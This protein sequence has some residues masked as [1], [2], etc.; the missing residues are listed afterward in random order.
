[1]LIRNVKYQYRAF[2]RAIKLLDK[3]T[4]I[5]LY[6]S[7]L[8]SR[9]NYGDCVWDRCTRTDACRLQSVQNMAM[10][11]MA[12]AKPLE[13]AR[14][15]L[16]EW[17]LLSLD[18]KRLLRSLVLFYKLMDKEG[19]GDLIQMLES[20]K[21]TNIQQHTRYSENGFFIPGYR[22]DYSG[23]AYFVRMIRIWSILP[24]DIKE[25]KTKEIFKNKIYK[26]LLETDDEALH[27]LLR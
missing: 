16:K 15:Y 1:M 22:T 7:S 4:Q 12:H 27:H 11:R 20:Y 19:P 5:L 6:N 10:K 23:N 21:R 2:S 24:S 8:A 26:M 17:G 18:K 14:P 25:S 9:F 13:S 3:D